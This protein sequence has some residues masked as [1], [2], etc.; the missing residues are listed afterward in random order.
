MG[1][2]QLAVIRTS[3]VAATTVFVL[4]G[5]GSG[6]DSTESA[7]AAKP[8]TPRSQLVL[9][10]SE[11]PAGIQYHS[12]S[13]EQYS[14]GIAALAHSLHGATFRPA[15]C[16]QPAR[17][18]LTSGQ[19]LAK[20]ASSAAGTDPH[21]VGA[22]YSTVVSDTVLDLKAMNKNQSG[23]C[24]DITASIAIQNQA[25]TQRHRFTQGKVPAAVTATDAL[26][27][28]E[29]TDVVIGSNPPISMHALR[30]YAI[31]RGFTVSLSMQSRGAVDRATF[32]TTF[33][34]AVDKVRNAR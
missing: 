14:A 8:A 25:T 31:I 11:F 17:D 4:A 18:N 3:I 7:A 15:D 29:D 23:A 34:K 9:S 12:T 5:C 24:A 13:P 30:G 6:N 21:N 19:N 32:D 10:A 26:V 27:F 33:A 20:S 1:T 28:A 16:T 22:T 2:L